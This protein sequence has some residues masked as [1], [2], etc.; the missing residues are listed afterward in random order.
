MKPK[1]IVLA[2]LVAAC[3]ASALRAAPDAPVF[4]DYPAAGAWSGRNPKPK[5]TTPDLRAFRTRITDAAREKPNFAGHFRVVTWGCGSSCVMG[6]IIDLNSGAV[7]SI[8]FSVCCNRA[9]SDDFEPVRFRPG[10]RLIAF[11]GLRDEEEPMGAHWYEFDGRSLRFIRT[12]AD[13]GTFV[14]R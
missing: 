8:P 13:D 9:E 7:T 3:P 12:V 10:S 6:A 4:A 14:T 5:L 2:L 1:A 11:Q